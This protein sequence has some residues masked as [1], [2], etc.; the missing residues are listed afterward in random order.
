MPHRFPH[1]SSNRCSRLFGW[2]LT[3]GISTLFVSS[4]FGVEQWNYTGVVT[5]KVVRGGKPLANAQV[6]LEDESKR[7]YEPVL[8]DK[9]GVYVLSGVK[10]G[11]YKLLVWLP[12]MEPNSLDIVAG[13]D[14]TNAPD[15]ALQ[16]EATTPIPVAKLTPPSTAAKTITAEEAREFVRNFWKAREEGNLE[17]VM[18]A[19]APEV[20]YYTDGV[21]D[22]NA[23]RKDQKAYSNTYTRI[24]FEL[25]AIDVINRK[26]ENSDS[27]Q[28][29]FP[30][31]YNGSRK[32]KDVSG[33]STETWVLRKKDGKLQIVDCKAQVVRDT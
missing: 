10:P 22:R 4:L 23:I 7:Q 30:F 31:R 5:G 3:L 8:T 32:T 13:P 14:V 17:V 6:T 28:V 21:K 26:G 12:G 20:N 15:F 29:R 25:G 24:T 27:I 2:A 19:F 1:S 11:K 18:D 9:T 33:S 16:G